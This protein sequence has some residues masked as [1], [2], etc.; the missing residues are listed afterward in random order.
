[1]ETLL[2]KFMTEISRMLTV[3]RDPSYSDVF[4]TSHELRIFI[5]NSRFV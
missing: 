2:L 4:L 3:P 1:M 5:R